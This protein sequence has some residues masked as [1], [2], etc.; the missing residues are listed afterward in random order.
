MRDRDQAP[1]GKRILGAAPATDIDCD[2]FECLR[3]AWHAR[4]A[5]FMA[6]LDDPGCYDPAGLLGRLQSKE[7]RK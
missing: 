7:I 4:H 1:A 3:A 6:S 5:A 2:E